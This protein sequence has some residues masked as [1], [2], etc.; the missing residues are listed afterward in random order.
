MRTLDSL[1]GRLAAATLLVCLAAGPARA[2]SASDA[3]PDPGPAP[4]VVEPPPRRDP[5]K[6]VV[7]G[8]VVSAQD[9]EALIE[10]QVSVVGGTQKTLTDVDGRYEL[11]LPPGLYELRVFYELHQPQRVK[12]VEVKA[13]TEQSL[14]VV[15]RADGDAVIEVVVEADAD[16]SRA[17][18]QL[19]RRKKAAVVSDAVSGEDIARTPDSSAADAMKRVVGA[20]I[21]DGKFVIIRGLGGRYSLALLEGVPVPSPEPDVPALPLDLFPASLLS[22]ITVAKTASPD[23]PGNFA[24]GA[25]LVDTQQYP[26]DFTLKLKVGLSGDTVSTFSDAPSYAGGSTDWLGYDDGTRALPDAIPRDR[27]AVEG[28]GITEEDLARM[29][30][31]FDQTWAT[32]PARLG[33]NYSLGVSAGDSVSLGGRKLGWLGAVAYGRSFKLRVTEVQA[34]NADLLPTDSF[35]E[36]S[37]IRIANLGALASLAYQLDTGHDV[38]LVSL[39]TRT[40]EDKAQ[41]TFG[42]SDGD[43][44]DVESQRLQFVA[45]T[46][47]FNQLRGRHRFSAAGDLELTWQGNLTTATR[48]EPDTR[49]ISYRVDTLGVS[50]FISEPG[51]GERFFGSLDDLSAGGGLDLAL[52]L[53]GWKPKVGAL[54]TSSS[55]TSKARRFRYESAGR[56]SDPASLQLPPDE[57]F[58]EATLGPD[59][60]FSES[61]SQTDG[62]EAEQLV[63]AGYAL[64]DVSLLDPFRFVAGARLEQATTKLEAGSP[65]AVEETVPEGVD[66][67]DL[68]VLPS[69]NLV[70]AV[71]PATNVRLA[72]ARTVARPQFRELAP[73]RY[74]DFTRRRSVSGNTELERTRIHNGDLRLEWFPGETEVLA[75]SVFGKRFDAPIEQVI[76]NEAGDLSFD[77]AERAQ[78]LGVELEAR[79]GLGRIAGPAEDFAL[80]ANLTFVDSSIELTAEQAS[81]QA[82]A[83]RPLQGQSPYVLNGGLRW[84]RAAWGTEVQVLYNVFGARIAEVAAAGYPDDVYLEEQHR[85][86]ATAVQ[87]LPYGFDLKVSATNLLDQDVVETMADKELSRYRP[88]LGV[89]ATLSWSN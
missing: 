38:A 16:K 28:D 83:E 85:L 81:K 61:T 3:A 4:E 60:L 32:S 65:Y 68:D 39:Y 67:T 57:I 50:R 7:R 51:S 76:Q 5:R 43:S 88:G 70:W 6:G 34:Y 73:F 9:G 40:G 78:V 17:A 59:F 20:T 29:G 33:P 80:V 24:G 19:E 69:A 82:N 22:S 48:Y 52:P 86:D 8:T 55:R 89:S 1:G 54:V 46:L 25:L 41:H 21:E 77:N 74:T 35:T 66:R 13:G 72:Y 84:L 62:Y 2:Q 31:S 42:F 36:T 63:L 26:S 53:G 47:Q 30:G 87:S 14:D 37:G 56:G 27:P 44:S 71:G 11:E 12:H 10:A 18:V 45:R 23:L 49:D 79:V 64:V 58:G 75:A 15:L